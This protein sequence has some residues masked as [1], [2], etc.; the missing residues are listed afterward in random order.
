MQINQSMRS[1]F[2]ALF[3]LILIFASGMPSTFAELKTGMAADVVVGQTDF[4][5]GS[6]DQGG[7]AGA[8]T[9][10]NPV[11]VFSDGTRL[12]IGVYWQ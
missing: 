1:L 12:I 4:T 8:N 3:L 7:S 10:D 6:D 9:L 11:G 2:L 5:S